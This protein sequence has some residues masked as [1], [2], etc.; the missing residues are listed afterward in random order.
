M[1]Q[2]ART[3]TILSAVFLLA[4]V[5]LVYWSVGPKAAGPKRPA[6]ETRAAGKSEPAPAA[7]SIPL[8]QPVEEM[9]EAIL[10]AAASGKIEDLQLALEFNELKPET[11]A[12]AGADPIA[13]WKST[14]ADGEG[15][16]VLAAIA[17]ILALRPAVVRAGADIENNK[18]YV[19][20]YLAEQPLDTLAP[21]ARVDLMRLV[22]A[23]AAA[24]MIAAKRYQGWRLSIG[25]DGTWHGLTRA[26]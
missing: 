15:Y 10:H 12:P 21:A 7:E 18:V 24:K 9:R 23:E 14:S 1:Q 26:Q 4:L 3:T 19:W 16:E 20:P 5:P 2:N 13:Y 25:A 6:A 17:N 11:D 22:P 8:P